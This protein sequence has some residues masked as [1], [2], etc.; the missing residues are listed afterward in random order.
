MLDQM[1][2]YRTGQAQTV[3]PRPNLLQALVQARPGFET[4]AS[5]IGRIAK[6]PG[7]QRTPRAMPGADS[8]FPISPQ[9]PGLPSAQTPFMSPTLYGGAG[10]Y[11][12]ADPSGRQG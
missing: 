5:N 3:A 7:A 6:W 9:Y 2:R 1:Q 4:A 11:G 8:P 12:L 10:G